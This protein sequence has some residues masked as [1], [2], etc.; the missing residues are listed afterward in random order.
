MNAE[1][2]PRKK[3]GVISQS[4]RQLK[5]SSTS[6]QHLEENETSEGER[7][8]KTKL[9]SMWNNMKYGN[10]PLLSVSSYQYLM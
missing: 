4:S 8:V 9:L 3:Y 5:V 10:T 7:K 1:L 6:S 2:V